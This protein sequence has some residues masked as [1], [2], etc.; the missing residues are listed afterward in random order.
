M[1]LPYSRTREPDIRTVVLLTTLVAL[2]AAAHGLLVRYRPLLVIGVALAPFATASIVYELERPLL[3]GLLFLAFALVLLAL[4]GGLDR[5]S[6]RRR[7]HHALVLGTIVVAFAAITASLPGVAR[8]SLLPWRDW[9][10]SSDSGSVG[11]RYVWNQT[12]S[13][14]RWPAKKTEV[15]QV[16]SP[17]RGYWRAVVLPEFDGYRWTQGAYQPVRDAMGGTWL[18]TDGFQNPSGQPTDRVSFTVE[19][20]AEPYLVSAGQPV[21]YELPLEPGPAQIDQD[22]IVRTTNIPE[23]GTSYTVVTK[24]ADPN[25]ADLRNAGTSYPSSVTSEGLAAFPDMPVPAFGTPNR[26]TRMDQLFAFSSANPTHAGW[27]KVYESVRTALDKG[28]LQTPYDT[29]IALETYF[30][31]HYSY[32]EHVVLSN[33]NGPPL[34]N[35]I[36]NGTAGYCQMFSGSMAELLR[37]LGIP[38]GSPRASPAGRSTRT[39]ASGG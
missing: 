18:D 32:D 28:Q 38:A 25:P 33:A 34:P 5:V 1:T 13:G 16:E 30:R 11:V 21:R 24:L 37:L 39:S 8:G 4:G 35:W 9:T 12:Y 10:L 29:V 26:E 17:Q 31:T 3:R 14:L 15:L 20:L 27:K 19:G 2:L 22:G 6:E 36:E 23:R 7:P